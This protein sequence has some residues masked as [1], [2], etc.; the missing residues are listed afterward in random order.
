M[1]LRSCGYAAG[2]GPGGA[3]AGRRS[4]LIIYCVTILGVVM[5]AWAA[6]VGMGR[7]I[8]SSVAALLLAPLVT[9]LLAPAVCFGMSPGGPPESVVSGEVGSSRPCQPLGGPRPPGDRCCTRQAIRV[10]RQWLGWQHA[11]LPADGRVAAAGERCC[12]RRA[13]QVSRQWLGWQH[14]PRPVDGRA[15]AAGRVGT[16]P[17]GHL[18]LSSVAQAGLAIRSSYVVRTGVRRMP[19][20]TAPAG[21]GPLISGQHEAGQEARV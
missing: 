4:G 1:C 17:A 5:Q 13:I 10:G 8:Q 12:T 18:S 19:G 2:A 20:H 6:G 21:I 15:A 16:H 7:T 3:V 9:V 14:A 11:P